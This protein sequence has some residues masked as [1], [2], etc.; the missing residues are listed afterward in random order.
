MFTRRIPFS[1]AFRARAPVVLILTSLLLINLRAPAPVSGEQKIVSIGILA[2]RGPEQVY[3]EWTPTADYL[4]S[5][6]PQHTFVITPLNPDEI[7]PAVRDGRVDFL[8]TNS[9]S[10]VE[11]EALY[12][13]SRILTLVRTRLGVEYTVY[14]AVIFTRADREDITGL[15]DLKGRSFM[16]AEQTS[17]GGFQMAWRE[18]LQHGIDPY[19]HFKS[20]EFSGFPQDNV[21]YAVRDGLVDA[22]TV[23][24]DI[25]EDMAEE[26]KI[27][28]E[29]FRILNPMKTQ[30][31]P[32]VHS[33][34]LYP[35][36]P[37]ARVRQTPEDLA[38]KVA[39]ALLNMPPDSPA[40]RAA[41]IAG[42]TIPL[43]YQ[44]VHECLRELRAG[45][46]RDFG[47]ITLTQ[48][49]RQYWVLFA[50]IAAV[51]LVMA[52]STVYVQRIN[53]RLRQARL[54]AEYLACTDYLTGLL[55]RRAFMERLEAEI[56]RSKREGAPVSIILADIDHFKNIN[57]SYGHQ[58]G[59][60]VIQM[61]AATISRLCRPYDFTG[62]YGGEEFIVCL[63]GV[64]GRKAV[65][66]AERMRSSV[67]EQV[68][69]LPE[70]SEHPEYVKITVSFGVASLEG[71][72][73]GDTDS[74]ISR[75]DEALY[76]AKA[77]GRNRTCLAP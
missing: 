64:S 8:L 67:E 69:L 39:V 75:A 23:R 13:A 60:T 9:S 70:K 36:W 42:W 56:A 12:G 29:S 73:W 44:P 51:L 48:A 46:Y 19:T 77:E 3:L 37:L 17:F 30:G 61:L 38:R 4:N 52:G 65:R 25:L 76:R 59:D 62:R 49:V 24:T 47:K 50:S 7:G 21:V 45:P 28:L 14:G 54:E 31:F 2:N 6:L 16:A 35:E 72:Q 18:L 10:Y 20:L 68:I 15:E 55:N 53:R 40:A 71:D 32:P 33:T 27:D 41:K 5:R 1:P 34:R 63:P 58:A 57:D 22:G 43:D 74:L 26:G 66:I 11:M